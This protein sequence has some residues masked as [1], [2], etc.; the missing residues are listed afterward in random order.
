MLIGVCAVSVLGF[1]GWA[2]FSASIKDR[3]LNRR[4]ASELNRS[5]AWEGTEKK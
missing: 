1:V 3:E 5:G 2:A 4:I